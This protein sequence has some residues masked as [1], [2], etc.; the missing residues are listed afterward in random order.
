MPLPKTL[1]VGDKSVTKEGLE[2]EIIEYDRASNLT[3]KFTDYPLCTKKTTAD[4]FRK[5][6]I[7]CP[8][9]PSVQGRGYM[10]EGSHR[11]KDG[12][13]VSKE[14]ATWQGMLQRCY[15]TTSRHKWPT[16]IDCEV[17]ERWLNFQN[18]AEDIK[19]LPNYDE[20]KSG[21]YALDKDGIIEGNKT[22]GP[23]TCQFLSNEENGRLGMSTRYNNH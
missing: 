16:Y 11:V 22:Y 4:Y 3:I 5:G 8:Y 17:C 20:W 7:K 14:Y 12:D 2:I 10:G 18:F 6:S 21:G 19:L 23:D 13:R 9:H 15:T 1:N